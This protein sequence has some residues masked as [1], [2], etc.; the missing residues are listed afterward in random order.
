MAF[1]DAGI[2]DRDQREC[3]Q[4]W[5]IGL[6]ENEFY[7]GGI[8]RTDVLRLEHWFECAGWALAH[9]QKPLE[10]VG[11]VLGGYSAAIMEFD[12]FLQLE[13]PGQFVGTDLMTG[14]QPSRQLR[15]IA[16]IA[17]ETVI[18]VE[19]NELHWY[20]VDY[21]RIEAL[22]QLIGPDQLL[23]LVLRYAWIAAQRNHCRCSG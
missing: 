22:G 11:D 16:D 6:V 15:G 2:D 5:C 17:I 13:S 1:D 9:G 19:Q 21:V 23:G 8:D 3:G 12:T 7:G 18:G 14:G 10:A 4:E 20:V